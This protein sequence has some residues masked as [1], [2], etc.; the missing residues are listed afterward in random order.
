MSWIGEAET[1]QNGL[2]EMFLSIPIVEKTCISSTNHLIVS[3]RQTSVGYLM[4]YAHRWQ[5]KSHHLGVIQTEGGA[6]HCILRR[7]AQFAFRVS[8]PACS[9]RS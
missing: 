8:Y 1:N 2:Q 6:V 3:A 7:F 4:P 5:G 9:R